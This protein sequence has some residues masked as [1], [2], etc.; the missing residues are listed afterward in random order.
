MAEMTVHVLVTG[1]VQGVSYRAFTRRTALD[2]GITGWVRNLAD[3]R[4]EALL[5][6]RHSAVEAM[7]A[8][9]EQGPPAAVVGRVESEQQPWQP[10]EGFEI[11]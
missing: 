4:V 9:L 10:C 11:R 8:R 5:S 6:G 1:R 3:G 7:I 2:H